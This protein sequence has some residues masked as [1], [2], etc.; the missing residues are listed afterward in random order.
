MGEA[1]EGS[2]T[3]AERDIEDAFV[4]V[5]SLAESEQVKYLT[6]LKVQSDVLHSEVC[7]LLK[8]FGGFDALLEGHSEDIHHDLSDAATVDGPGGL[9]RSLE[10]E[11]VPEM[12]GPY[13]ILSKIGQGGMG[14]VYLAEQQTPKR[15]VALKLIP[16]SLISQNFL[17]RFEGEYQALALMNHHHI[18]RIY[19]ANSTDDGN[20]YFVMEF[21]DGV[22]IVDYCKA[23][24]LSVNATLDLFLQ[25]CEGVQHAHQKAIIHRD[26]KPSNILVYED[27]GRPLVKIIDFGMAKELEGSESLMTPKT[28]TGGLSGTPAYMSPEQLFGGGERVDTRGDI[29]AL[30][31]ILYELLVGEHPYDLK[32]LRNLP[33]DEALRT[34]RVQEPEAPSKRTGKTRKLSRDLD[35]LILRAMAKDVSERYGSVDAL[36][37]DIHNFQEDRPVS[38]LSRNR[39]HVLL[40]FLKRNKLLISLFC[41]A[42]TGLL[43]G[44]ILAVSSSVKAQRAQAQSQEALQFLKDAFLSPDPR[45]AGRHAKLIDYLGE[46]EKRLDHGALDSAEMSGDLRLALGNTWFNL[47]LYEEASD[48]LYVAIDELTHALGENHEATLRAKYLLGRIHVR[49]RRYEEAEFLYLDVLRRQGEILGRDHP[50]TVRTMSAF[51]SLDRLVRRYDSA[52]R[53][54]RAAYEKQKDILGEAHVDTLWSLVGLANTYFAKKDYESALPYYEH[55]FELQRSELGESDPLTMFTHES[56]AICLY[57]LRCYAQAEDEL[58]VLI[59]N[60]E[61][62]LGADNVEYLRSLDWFCRTLRRTGKSSELV[63]FYPHLISRRRVEENGNGQKTLRLMYDYGFALFYSN[64]FEASAHVLGEVAALWPADLKP[65]RNLGQSLYYSANALANHGEG[66]ESLRY[67]EEAAE[68]ILD[69]G[70]LVDRAEFYYNYSLGYWTLGDFLMVDK[71]LCQAFE[72]AQ[73]LPSDHWLVKQLHEAWELSEDPEEE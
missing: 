53:R 64:D 73:D 12:V 6:S 10:P 33:L 56:Y 21:I 38:A 1:T 31:V 37:E 44:L 62:E 51:G 63:Q 19:D 40:K 29:Y 34:L 23:K 32:A 49:Q 8:D 20:A 72:L 18:A 54:F 70:S 60:R 66:Q 69:H 25:V 67:F 46:A 14:V 61:R 11:D 71:Y 57:R 52:E 68:F 36:F 22:S 13:R 2:S 27:Q 5:L 41:T 47:G 43:V 7:A 48:S 16:R 50:A 9:V 35:Q 4:H 45:R 39:G 58:R 59:K 3:L 28:V 42:V 15:K 26:L 24:A 30:G 55:A 65:Q 17:A